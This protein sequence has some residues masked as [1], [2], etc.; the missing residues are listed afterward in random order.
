ML[1]ENPQAARVRYRTAVKRAESLGFVYRPLAEILVAEP[2]D[3]ILQ[4]VESTI[5]EPAKSP[6][7]DAV[8]GAVD[9]PDDKIS[10]ALD[11]RGARDSETSARATK[12]SFGC[13]RP[14]CVRQTWRCSTCGNRNPEC[15]QPEAIEFLQ[16]VFNR[17]CIGASFVRGTFIEEFLV[18]SLIPALPAGTDR[19]QFERAPIVKRGIYADSSIYRYSNP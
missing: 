6:S 16:R 15:F 1:G 7:V 4:R 13:K 17:L 2:L 5:G 18:A 3:T 10:E 12:G 19:E 14:P 11:L 8:G 9:R